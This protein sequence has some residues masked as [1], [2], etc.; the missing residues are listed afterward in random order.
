[1]IFE[2]HTI[3]PYQFIPHWLL[4][5]SLQITVFHHS[6]VHTLFYLSS[7]PI[8]YYLLPFSCFPHLLSSPLVLSFLSFY[9]RFLSLFFF[10]PCPSF[11]SSSSFLNTPPSLP[12]FVISPLLS[13]PLAFP[14]LHSSCHCSSHC[15]LSPPFPLNPILYF[16]HRAS[17]LPLFP[18]F[19]LTLSP[20]S[21]FKPLPRY[22]LCP[23]RAFHYRSLTPVLNALCIVIP[24]F[25]PLPLPH[26]ML[27]YPIFS[28][29]RSAGLWEHTY[30]MTS[31]Q[32]HRSRSL[33]PSPPLCVLP[34]YLEWLVISH[35]LFFIFFLQQR[36]KAQG[37]KQIFKKKPAI[38]FFCFAVIH[39]LNPA[40]TIYFVF[41][42]RSYSHH[43][44]P[45]LS[46]KAVLVFSRTL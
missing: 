39:V 24:L 3:V 25:P 1:M 36:K 31:D 37:H 12:S 9:L 32:Q 15:T 8:F 18:T 16:A 6:L 34:P 14:L 42:A 19:R 30:V 33:S 38:H 43:L 28:S 44:F 29:R 41:L 21:P 26:A 5:P 46:L 10:P 20:A 4:F 45:L 11:S 22:P 23:S 40:L 13:F 17:C 27:L 35:S 7:G 2:L